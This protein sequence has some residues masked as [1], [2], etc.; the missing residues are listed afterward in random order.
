M[1]SEQLNLPSRRRNNSWR[2]DTIALAS[3]A[4]PVLYRRNNRALRYRLTLGR[5]GLPRI[6]IPRRGSRQA[7]EQFALRH[8]DWLI[9]QLEKFEQQRRNDVWTSGTQIMF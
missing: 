7:A 9:M 3:Q 6:T 5:D 2:G 1:T 8:R 4:V